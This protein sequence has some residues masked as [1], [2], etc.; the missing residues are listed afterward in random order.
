MK[1][2]S[3]FFG[4]AV[5][6]VDVGAVSSMFAVFQLVETGKLV[7]PA[8]PVWLSCLLPCYGL[9]CLLLRV[10]RTIRPLIWI[11]TVVFLVQIGLSWAIYGRFAAGFGTIFSLGAWAATYY[12]AGMLALK[13]PSADKIMTAFELC[14]LILLFSLFYCSVKAISFAC[15]LPALVAA[16]FALAALIGRRTAS[17]RNAVDNRGT[18]T[19]LGAISAF[20]L[21]ALV[22]AG[23]AAGAVKNVVLGLWW[24]I[25]TAAGLL[26]RCVRR[27]LDWLVSRIPEG[28]APVLPIESPVAVP[29]GEMEAAEQLMG[30]AELMLYVLVGVLALAALVTVVWLLIRGGGRFK[31]PVP[32]AGGRITRRRKPGCG[33][34]RWLRRVRDAVRFHVCRILHRD[35]APGL[36]VWLER[37]KAL[38]RKGRKPSESCREFLLSLLPDYPGGETVLLTLAE[39]LDR[40][41]FGGGSRL[42]RR[43]IRV[44][45]KM[46][47]KCPGNHRK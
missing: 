23:L 21:G 33:L 31:R 41:Y 36:F 38:S 19:V 13:P 2:N 26:G 12:H 10:P 44:M 17:G 32:T 25:K 16:L 28:E 15:A 18:G 9:L 3:P 47:R 40:H 34:S 39:D 20:A 4:A 29:P 45:R 42:S 37:R 27:L 22:V 30:S 35:T 14:V 8:L 5:L 43:E 11:S 6:L 24:A 1:R 46:L 7:F